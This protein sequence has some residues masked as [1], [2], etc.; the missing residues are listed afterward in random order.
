MTVSVSPACLSLG[1]KT[2][3]FILLVLSRVP[4]RSVP[5]LTE[6]GVDSVDIARRDLLGSAG[7]LP[8]GRC[9]RE[10]SSEEHVKVFVLIES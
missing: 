6:F 1:C 9:G 10:S 2:F 3:N 7:T 8:S 4:L 5:E